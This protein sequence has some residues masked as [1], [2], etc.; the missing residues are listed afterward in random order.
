MVVE[1]LFIICYVPSDFVPTFISLRRHHHLAKLESSAATFG[2]LS[3]AAV[4]NALCTVWF[5]AS[6][7]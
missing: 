5:L 3:N 2:N 6:R 4:V 7:A 1:A